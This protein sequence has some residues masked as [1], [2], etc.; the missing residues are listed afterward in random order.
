VDVIIAHACLAARNDRSALPWRAT[1]DGE[2]CWPALATAAVSIAGY[3]DDATTNAELDEGLAHFQTLCS[4]G[5]LEEAAIL[6]A[7]RDVMDAV[8]EWIDGQQ[9]IVG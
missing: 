1:I 5:I 3:L 9:F 7:T 8:I 6:A 2:D 4:A